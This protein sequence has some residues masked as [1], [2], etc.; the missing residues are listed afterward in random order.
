MVTL[1]L[2]GI[3]KAYRDVEV[4]HDIDLDIADGEFVVFVG[5]SGCGKSTLLRLIAGLDDAT[6]GDILIDGARVNALPPVQR[7]VAMVFQTY[8]LYPHMTVFKNMAFGLRRSGLGRAG[9]RRRVEEAAEALELT[10]LLGRLPRELSGGQRQRVAIGRAI[11]RDPELFLLDE[12]LSN[13]D[14]GLRA[15]TRLEIQRLHRRLDATMIYVTHDQVEAMTLADRIVVLNR[16]RVEQA[17]APLDLYRRP[18]NLFVATFLGAPTMNLRAMAVVEA[19]PGSVRLTGEGVTLTL[20]RRVDAAA[21]EML[22]VGIRP[23][24][25]AVVAPGEGPFQGTVELIEALGESHLVH[26]RE[27]GGAVT[28]VR[29][30]GDPVRREGEV[31]CLRADDAKVHLFAADGVT[32]AP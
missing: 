18:A 31:I 11:V 10:P 13:L 12:P 23:E 15:Q 29:V 28:V 22:T 30:A 3:C 8:A 19:A 21:G 4:L 26:V 20:P 27:A 24:D 9:V 25:I 1:A 17:G 16:G 2:R 14:A 32:L 5:P 7:G 6:D